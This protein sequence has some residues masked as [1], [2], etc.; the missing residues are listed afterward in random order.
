MF[1]TDRCRSRRPCLSSV[2]GGFSLP[3]SLSGLSAALAPWQSWAPPCSLVPMTATD[4]HASCHKA[5]QALGQYLS[6]N[7]Q[8][9]LSASTRLLASA[10][11]ALSPG[12]G[13]LDNESCCPQG[14]GDTC[15][16]NRKKPGGVAIV[17]S[18]VFRLAI[19]MYHMVSF[20]A[21]R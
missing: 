7:G 11:C 9:S 3:F 2:E 19:R 13:K 20:Q 14:L 21:I 15:G 4:E 12:G 18:H 16:K 1:P 5:K 8:W 10:R 17:H 6:T